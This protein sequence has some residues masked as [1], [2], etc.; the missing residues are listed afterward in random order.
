MNSG[1]NPVATE[2]V[3]GTRR[4]G[5]TLWN[6]ATTGIGCGLVLALSGCISLPGF[7]DLRELPGFQ[8][9]LVREDVFFDQAILAYRSTTRGAPN[10]QVLRNA[11][12]TKI[13]TEQD[14]DR[15]VASKEHKVVGAGTKSAA[16]LLAGLY[17]PYNAVTGALWIVPSVPLLATAPVINKAVDEAAEADCRSGQAHFATGE[18]SEALR[19]WNRAKIILPTLQTESDIDYWRGRALEEEGRH[20]EAFLAYHLFLRYSE[21][22]WPD[23]FRQREPD[24]MTWRNVAADI[25]QRLDVMNAAR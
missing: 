3:S 9:A 25:E 21:R 5:V 23:F 20:A 22:T 17:L 24:E 12:G 8:D 19:D 1:Q 16:Y 18:F 10:G 13:Q 6:A 11:A 2:P 14:L 4:V 7:S 15:L